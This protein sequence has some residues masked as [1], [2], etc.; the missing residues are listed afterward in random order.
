MTEQ[1]PTEQFHASSFL[2]GHNAEYIEQCSS[3][4]LAIQSEATLLSKQCPTSAQRS[5]DS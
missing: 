2:Q 3:K 5:G 1:F 4:A